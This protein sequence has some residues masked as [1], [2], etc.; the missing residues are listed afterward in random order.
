LRAILTDLK[1]RRPIQGGS[2]I[3]QQLIRS[4]FLTTKKTFQRKT[5][6]LVLTLELERRYPK[7]QILEWYLNLIPFGGNLYGVEA[8]SQ[9]F[10]G[11]PVSQISLAESAL[12][13]SLIKAPS[14]LWPYGTHLDELL[15]R[16][17][18]VLER[19]RKANYI[20]I[21]QEQKAKTENIEFIQETNV[22]KKAHHF[23]MYVKDYL[24][25]K[26]GK[27]FLT[28][29]GLKVYTT[30]DIDLQEKA[31][32]LLKNSIEE[33]KRYN[34]YNGAL[35]SLEAK[36]G[37]ILVMVGSKDF[38]GE[39]FPEGCTP[40]VNCKFDPQV[41]TSLS[42]RQPGSAIKP[43]VYAQAFLQGF[44]PKT[45]IWDVPTE[46]N[47]NC[48]P[49]ANDLTDKYG[50]KC[51][52][53]KNYDDKF[54]G[55]INLRSSLAQSRN[56]PSVKVLY[57]AGLSPTLNLIRNFG[58][59][60][61]KDEKAYGLALVLGGGEVRLLEIVGAYSV[62]ANNGVKVPLNFIKKIEDVNGNIIEEMKETRIKVIPSQI[63]KELNDIL[64]DNNARAPIFGFDS[65]LY[66][67]D[68]DVA[69]KT[70]TTQYF[71]DAWAIGYTPSLV[72][73]VWVGN[74]DNSPTK[75]P[76]VMSA[77]AIWNKFMQ[78]ALKKFDKE[79]FEKP[80]EVT[81][82][83]PVL[84][85]IMPEPHTI[86]HYINKNEPQGEGNSQDDPQYQH[87]ETAVQNW[88]KN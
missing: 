30:L 13:A 62:F 6:E 48:S 49:D 18:Y 45:V 27:D 38:F 32:I 76:G 15:K 3:T 71:N 73:G 10:F 78:E 14:H 41:N 16:K 19:M 75:K 58:I 25:N 24:E 9:T 34:A 8:A 35:V 4:Y 74:N 72:A 26:Y 46:F 87:W 29:A 28:T 42:L 23:V 1:L 53:P 7:D 64:S 47:P 56:L 67:K 70:G 36:T 40:G 63:A 86:L 77:G 20:T 39:P 51:Y 5:R 83:K 57:L 43:F 84:D 66:F 11:K 54:K 82:G 12:L 85:G 44:T 68:Y 79:S 50:I 22:F 52:H 31:E 33:L 2:T 21:E 59:T 80:E 17:D 88:L 69:V 81:T 37:E 55:L 60:S 65:A 61:L